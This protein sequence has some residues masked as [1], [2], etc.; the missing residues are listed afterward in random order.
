VQPGLRMAVL[1]VVE[2]AASD[3]GTVKEQGQIQEEAMWTAEQ[4]AAYLKVSKRWVHASA[5]AGN[6][7]A[8][9]LTGRKR[10]IL[11]RFVAAD[12]RAYARGE[13]KPEAKS[14]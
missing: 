9:R 3:G 13:W 12:I 1:K 8:T 2:T 10:N 5:H 11:W 6:L 14:A 4:V 7:P